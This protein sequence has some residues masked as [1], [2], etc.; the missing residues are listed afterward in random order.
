MIRIR[1]GGV[2][3]W[4]VGGWFWSGLLVRLFG[5]RR[6]DLFC[7]VC[8]FILCCDLGLVVCLF[9]CLFVCFF[10]CLFACLFAC[11]FVCFF[12][13]FFLSLFF[14]FD[15]LMVWVWFCLFDKLVYLV[16]CLFLLCV[17]LIFVIWCCRVLFPWV[18]WHGR[19]CW[20]AMIGMQN[21]FTEDVGDAK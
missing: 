2:L 3:G 16:V 21:V 1:F 10:C 8:Y 11:L 20:W 5:R 13:S 17:C 14:L 12:L 19:S 18:P 6:R 15:W 7:L 9:V 4:L